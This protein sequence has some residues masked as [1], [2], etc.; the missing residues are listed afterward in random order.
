M[1]WISV[2]DYLQDD[3]SCSELVIEPGLENEGE[4]YFQNVIILNK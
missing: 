1:L 2:N 3:P 4:G